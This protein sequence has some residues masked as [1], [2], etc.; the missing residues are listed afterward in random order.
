M[1]LDDFKEIMNIPKNVIPFSLK[2]LNVPK[3]MIDLLVNE[4][5]TKGR[6]DNNI[7]DLCKDDVNDILQSVYG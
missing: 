5:F 3:N 6:M 7:V 1:T 2:S 4:S